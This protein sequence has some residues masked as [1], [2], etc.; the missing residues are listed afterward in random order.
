MNRSGKEIQ[1][2]PYSLEIEV[3]FWWHRRQL[4]GHL[5][6]DLL[7]Q[8]VQESLEDVRLVLLDEGLPQELR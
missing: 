8:L 2:V 6:G 1:R 5:G 7:L 3:P 4:L